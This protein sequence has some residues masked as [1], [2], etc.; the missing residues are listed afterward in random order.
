MDVDS[1][2]TDANYRT[3]RTRQ[4][5]RPAE[6]DGAAHL[7]VTVRS[8]PFRYGTALILLAKALRVCNNCL[9]AS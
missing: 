7:T 8:V 2:I 9:T 4:V 1:I 3:T 5:L 6:I